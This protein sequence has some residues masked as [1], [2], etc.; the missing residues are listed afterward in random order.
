M[1]TTERGEDGWTVTTLKQY[2]ERRFEEQEKA[3]HAA[4]A[5]AEKAVQAALV[6]AKEAVDKAEKNVETWREASNEWRGAMNDRERNF[7]TKSEM[8][9]NLA[10]A[11]GLVIALVAIW[12]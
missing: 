2:V 6:S 8:R 10:A 12:R 3:V 7:V 1:P 11:V 5:A 9:A 4:L